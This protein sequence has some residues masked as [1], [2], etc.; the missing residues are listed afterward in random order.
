MDIM[1]T[2]GWFVWFFVPLWVGRLILV[3]F[4][5]ALFLI[6]ID[7]LHKHFIKKPRCQCGSRKTSRETFCGTWMGKVR[8]EKCSSSFRW[9]DGKA[10]WQRGRII[11]EDPIGL[12]GKDPDNFG[13]AEK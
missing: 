2:F 7:G 10:W 13:S 12:F 6:V 5:G 9:E 4:F 8:C 11:P 1:E 3:I